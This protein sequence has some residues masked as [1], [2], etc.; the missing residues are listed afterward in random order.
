VWRA[1]WR[2][3]KLDP[4]WVSSST[5]WGLGVSWECPTH[6]HR[7]TLMFRN[8]AD[9]GGGPGIHQRAGTSFSTLTVVEWIDLAPCFSGRIE[10]GQLFSHVDEN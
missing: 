7:L 3:D 9:G 4:E 1:V 2:L 10:T 8:A 6:A 5:R